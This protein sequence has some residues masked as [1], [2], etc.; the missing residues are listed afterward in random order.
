MNTKTIS[1]ILAD[2]HQVVRQG[3][4][5]LLETE[6]DFKIVGEVSDGIAATEIVEKEQPDVLVLDIEMKGM[7]GLEVARQVSQRSPKTNVIILSMHNNDDYVLEAL[8]AGAKGYVLKESSADEL[9]QAIR[10]V[11]TARR[12]LGY[13]LNE[14]V[15]D[16]YL[17]ISKGDKADP[18]DILT[19]REREILYLVAQGSTSSDI[20]DK[21]Y[22]SRRTV[23]VHRG[24]MMK[25][26][27]LHSMAQLI[28]Y[29]M[30]RGIPSQ[31]A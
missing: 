19:L 30:Q 24:S 31:N 11:M 29:A 26:L 14:Q 4:R 15:L 8:R 23:E 28:R 18:Y 1:I 2:D 13:P 20:A 7:K 17:Q 12:Y 3:I 5:A 9:V 22:I 10:T 6:S 16:T 27:G 21:L 25:K